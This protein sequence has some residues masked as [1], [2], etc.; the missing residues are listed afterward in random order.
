MIVSTIIFIVFTIRCVYFLK[1]N[2]TNA[3]LFLVV[4]L[5]ISIL[6]IYV[7][8]NSNAGHNMALHHNNPNNIIVGTSGKAYPLIYMNNNGI[9]E[10]LAVDVI[11]IVAQNMNKEVFFV[12]LPQVQLENALQDGEIDIIVDGIEWNKTNLDL[13][14][15]S[16]PYLYLPLVFFGIPNSTNITQDKQINSL[17]LTNID[18][19]NFGVYSNA[20]YVDKMKQSFNVN[21]NIIN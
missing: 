13:V 5:L 21:N 20:Q 7:L 15:F 18:N 6:S 3:L 8:S 14:K 2:T 4:F 10:G 19:Y 11:E 17:P 12:Q 1:I 9:P 16:N